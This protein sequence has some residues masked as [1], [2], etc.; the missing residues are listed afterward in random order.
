VGADYPTA[1]FLREAGLVVLPEEIRPREGRAWLVG[2]QGTRGVLRRRP[3][4]LALDA[5]LS[6][7]VTWLHGFMT[8]LAAVGFPSPR[9]LPCFD[10][11]SWIIAQGSLWEIVSF[12]PGH[13]VGW[14]ALPPT[15][16]IGALLGRYH[17][18]VRRIQVTGQRPAALPLVEVPRVLLSHKLDA[19]PAERTALIR[20]LAAQLADD[21][22]GTGHLA[23]ERVVIH[24]DFTNDNVV[25]HGSPPAASGVI[26]FALAH[27]ETPLADIG[28]GLWR[29]GRPHELAGRLDLS[30]IRR[31]VRGYANVVRLTPDQVSVIPLYV[32]GRGLQMIAKRVRAGQTDT[33]MLAQVLWLT[34]NAGEVGDALVAGLP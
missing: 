34:A 29:S 6:Q 31:F 27:V 17:G 11:M 8:R 24:G 18:A 3:V 19:I 21:L 25:A 20:Q 7:D 30:R 14:A 5:A 1:R 15:E 2:W 12:L 23:R 28:Y 26:D 32:R 16:E 22:D 9:P 13:A 10:G 33:G 4:P